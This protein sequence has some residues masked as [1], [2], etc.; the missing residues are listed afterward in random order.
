MTWEYGADDPGTRER[1][2]ED[3]EDGVRESPCGGKER[4]IPAVAC[5]LGEVFGVV[6][7]LEDGVSWMGE[8][9]RL[10]VGTDLLLLLLLL[11]RGSCCWLL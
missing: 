3:G 4:V 1:D 6:A 7:A 5:R 2:E 8:L 9:V 11:G 10:P